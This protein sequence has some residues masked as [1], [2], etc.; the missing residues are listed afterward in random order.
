M[1]LT[2]QDAVGAA[3]TIARLAGT[4]LLGTASAADPPTPKS[5]RWL[6][7]TDLQKGHIDRTLLA[8]NLSDYFTS[9]ALAD[10]PR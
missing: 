6:S 10:F 1:V 7:S 3:S 8:P 5:R 2:N 4:A 9:E